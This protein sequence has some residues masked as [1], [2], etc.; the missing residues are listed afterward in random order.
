MQ[1]ELYIKFKKVYLQLLI[2]LERAKVWDSTT[3]DDLNQIADSEIS[4]QESWKRVEELYGKD[5]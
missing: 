3:I 4:L 5:N 1:E 2:L